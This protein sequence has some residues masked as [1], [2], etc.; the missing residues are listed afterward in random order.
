MWAKGLVVL[1]LPGGYA[2]FT[3][4]Q[5]SFDMIDSTKIVIIWIQWKPKEMHMD[6]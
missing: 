6:V 3:Q 5:H 4:T 1:V 2:L